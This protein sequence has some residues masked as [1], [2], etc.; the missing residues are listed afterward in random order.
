MTGIDG[1]GRVGIRSYVAPT[2]SLS[3]IVTNGLVLNLDASNPLSYS[4]TGTVWTDLSGNGNNATLVNGPNFN[5]ANG[6]SIAFDGINDFARIAGDATSLSSLTTYSFDIWLKAS[7]AGNK[8]ILEKGVNSKMI[9]QPD[10]SNSI[11]YGDA[12]MAPINSSTIFNGLWKNYSVVQSSTNTMLYINGS[13]IYTASGGNSA[14]NNS[15]I[16]LMARSAAYPQAGNIG[17]FKVYN[18]VLSASEVLQNFDSTK[19]R[20]G[21][22][23]S[24]TTRTSAFAAA[25]GI[26]DATILNALNTFD[27]GLISNGLDTKMKA[28][29]PFVG[30]TANT[31]K[32]NFM[33]A[34][35]SDAAFRLQFNGGWVHNTTGAKPNGSNGYANTYLSPYTHLTLGSRH[36]SM[37]ASDN[38]QA[39]IY[40]IDMGAYDSTGQKSNHLSIRRTADN[41]VGQLNNWGNQSLTST[42]NTTGLLIVNRPSIS[43]SK[44]FKNN[45]LIASTTNDITGQVMPNFNM[46][47]GGS[48]DNGGFAGAVCSSRGFSLSSIGSGLSDTEASTFYALVQALQTSLSRQV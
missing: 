16:L 23:N 10:T 34:R 45:V 2:T 13:L 40:S 11:W 48:N 25:T 29:Y 18:R 35:D 14:A 38:S 8:V 28:L 17:S 9:I 47:L 15:D 7:Y 39:N 22:A 1:V 37:Y 4:G 19:E 26:T 30:G 36:L 5:S 46:F 20:F 24:Y 31:H 32:F 6:G 44:A 33:D 27:T 41:V 21:F 3:S 12:K 43:S 42:N